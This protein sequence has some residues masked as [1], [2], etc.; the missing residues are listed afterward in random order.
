MKKI[1]TKKFI[2]NS[3]LVRSLLPLNRAT[4]TYYNVLVFMLK[5]KTKEFDTKQ[6][7]S[8][9]LN[10]AYGMQVSYGLTGYGKQ[11]ALDVRFRYIR[12][13]FVDDPGY[14]DEVVHI[15]DQILNDPLLDESSF[16]EAKYLLSSRLRRQNDDPDSLAL[17]KALELA[18]KETSIAIP[19]QG[20]LDEIGTIEYD[21]LLSLYEQWKTIGKIVYGCGSFDEKVMSFLDSL[22][23][24]SAIRLETNQLEPGSPSFETIEKNISQTSIVQVYSTSTNV[25]SKDY[26]A[27]LLLNSI[28]GQSSM[29]L[30]FNNVREKH[31]LCYS[32]SSSL[33]RFDGALCISTGTSAASMDECI[34]LIDEQI[35][36][37]ADG[38]FT[39]EELEV[40][41]MDLIDMYRRQQDRPWAMI[42]QAFLDEVLRRS[43]TMQDR[44]ERIGSITKEQISE[45]GKRLSL[46][47]MAVVKEDHD[48]ETGL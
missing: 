43:D 30:L 33:I 19:V 47:S 15:M 8:V 14:I 2:D 31:S 13:E 26:Y 35:K 7:L 45:I 5:A 32:I 22:K 23:K 10:H 39:D 41:R 12:P 20:Y 9:A 21:R 40:A 18:G 34:R 27:L 36:V 28:L 3:V 46:V 4:I 29:S 25:C 37:C 11:V 1:Q 48:E 44:I 42:E 6:K 16:E 17:K 24:E 38:C